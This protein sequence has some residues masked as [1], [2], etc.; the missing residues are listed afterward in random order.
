MFIVNWFMLFRVN[1]FLFDYG[2]DVDGFVF[3]YFSVENYWFYF[4]FCGSV[5]FL[6]YIIDDV[7]IEIFGGFYVFIV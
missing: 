1:C 6:L 7:V 5:N 2:S 4:F 3:I